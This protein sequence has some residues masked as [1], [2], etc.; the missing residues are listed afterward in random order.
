[1]ITG[2]SW[3]QKPKKKPKMDPMTMLK[4]Y[5]DEQGLRLVDFFNKLDTDGS[6]TLSREEFK[7]K[8]FS[9]NITC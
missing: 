9:K 4:T 8:K 2:G 6:M 3:V 1:V 5:M 7:G